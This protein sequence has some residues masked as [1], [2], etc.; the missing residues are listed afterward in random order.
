MEVLEDPVGW[1]D[2]DSWEVA[3]CIYRLCPNCLVSIGGPAPLGGAGGGGRQV[4]EL[5]G[6]RSALRASGLVGEKRHARV[7]G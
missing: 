5:Q 2:F 7:A 4:P 1:G 6:P 3:L